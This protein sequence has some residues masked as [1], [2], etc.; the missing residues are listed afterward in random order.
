MND[1]GHCFK[2]WIEVR[3][4]IDGSIRKLPLRTVI[5]LKIPTKKA[6]SVPQS[7]ECLQIEDDAAPIEGE[8][9]EELVA[10]LRERYPDHSFERRVHR[11]RDLDAEHAMSELVKLLARSAMRKGL[12]AP[13]AATK[14]QD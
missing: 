8:T 12:S 9:W 3:A 11:E 10:K 7:R 6:K 13:T 14:G 5:H 4:L 2:Y 1:S